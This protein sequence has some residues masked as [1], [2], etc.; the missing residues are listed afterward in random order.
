MGE[1][2]VIAEG[3]P[4]V[5]GVLEEDE[6]LEFETVGERL[7]EKNGGRDVWGEGEEEGEVE[8]EGVSVHEN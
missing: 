3:V 2:D 4:A 8:V 7:F 6:D 5:V 1:V